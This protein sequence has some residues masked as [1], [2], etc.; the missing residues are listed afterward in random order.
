M[1]FGAPRRAP[2][3]RR[4]WWIDPSRERS[5]ARARSAAGARGSR[6]AR[7]SGRP[8][9]FWAAPRGAPSWLSSWRRAHA[10][11]PSGR[12]GRRRRGPASRPRWQE[13]AARE[14]DIEF[15]RE[16]DDYYSIAYKCG[17]TPPRAAGP[18]V[19]QHPCLSRRSL[20][21]LERGS[22]Q[23]RAAYVLK[24]D[25]DSFVYV[26]Q[27]RAAAARA[28]PRAGPRRRGAR[29]PAAARSC[30]ACC[31]ARHARG[32]SGGTASACTSRTATRSRPST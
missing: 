9:S 10:A 3:V 29:P 22:L 24:T 21:V 6:R 17:S 13:E 18:A 31:A 16:E 7:A 32:F 19:S 26:A 14:C 1:R 28:Q 30:C 4:R 15:V 2:R 12:P 8:A 20:E 25:D 11:R 5:D 27:A 23:E